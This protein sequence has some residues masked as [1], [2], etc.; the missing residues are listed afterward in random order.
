MKKKVTDSAKT[1]PYLRA[2]MKL[3]NHSLS[4]TVDRRVGVHQRHDGHGSQPREETAEVE[5]QRGA[6]SEA[7][8]ELVKD[9]AVRADGRQTHDTVKSQ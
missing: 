5:R 1:E 9:A 6:D 2:V 4:Y 8:V 7:D 3:T